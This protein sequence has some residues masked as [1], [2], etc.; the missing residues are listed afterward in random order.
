MR[1]YIISLKTLQWPFVVHGRQSRIL[2]MP[3]NYLVPLSPPVSQLQALLHSLPVTLTSFY[4]S[5]VSSSFPAQE[6]YPRP[7]SSSNSVSHCPFLLLCL[8][9]LGQ[10]CC[11]IESDSSFPAQC[12]G[13]RCAS[14]PSHP[15]AGIADPG[16]QCQLRAQHWLSSPHLSSC[17]E[18]TSS[19]WQ[20]RYCL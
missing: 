13:G 11:G 7:S 10:E 6:P 3:S 19:S 1:P 8:W 15:T 16:T 14:A 18:I 20:G 4:P 9:T 5:R 2:G 12:L 17:L